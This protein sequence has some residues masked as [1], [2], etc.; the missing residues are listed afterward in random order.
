MFTLYEGIMNDV[1]NEAGKKLVFLI[2][3]ISNRHPELTCVWHNDHFNYI[4]I[5]IIKIQQIAVV[6]RGK[7][8]KPL[9]I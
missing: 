5:G 6:C 9:F 3:N 2:R 4:E 7:N 1:I 8:S